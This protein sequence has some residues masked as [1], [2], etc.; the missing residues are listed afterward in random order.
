MHYMLIRMVKINTMTIPSADKYVEKL[1]LS[2]I[3][4]RNVKWHNHSGKHLGHFLYTA[5]KVQEMKTHV[6]TKACTYVHVHSSSIHNHS[7]W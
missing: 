6:Y 5:H 2:H 3:N 1:K 7:N 4:G